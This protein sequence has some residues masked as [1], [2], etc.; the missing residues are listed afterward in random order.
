[1]AE[2]PGA[3]LVVVGAGPIGLATAIEAAR[4]GMSVTVL[5]PREPPVDKACGEGLMPAARTALVRLGVEP[6][7]IPFRGIHYLAPGWSAVAPFRTGPGLG[8]RRTELS[9]ALDARASALGIRRLAVRAGVPEQQP[10]GVTVGGVTARWLVAADGLHSPTRRALGLDAPARPG[11][12]RAARY[13][14]R[15]HYRMPPW[16]DL[17]EVHWAADAEAYVTPVAPDLVGVAVLGPGGAPFDDW[18]RR[19]PALADR[20]SGAEA[21]GSVRGA[22]PLRQAARCRVQGR[23]LLVGDAAGYLDALTGE[24]IAVGLACARSLVECLVAGRPETY[25]TEW[26]RATRRYRLLTGALL[27]AA[28]RPALRR[29]IVPA[30]QRLPWLF[31]GIVDQLAR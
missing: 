17:V 16:T 28:G 7:G 11:R 21:A 3:D 8:V 24:G 13:G 5:D 12:R 10:D 18:L 19:F 31:T 26:W 29:A 9:R 15:R 25:E 14:L 22:G 6:D 2:R 23:A 27:A 4:A 20:L 30:A 1:M